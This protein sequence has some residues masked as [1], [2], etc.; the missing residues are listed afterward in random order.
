MAS[1]RVKR[2]GTIVHLMIS[3]DVCCNRHLFFSAPLIV[4]NIKE[5]SL[6]QVIVAVK[7]FCEV[8][9]IADA[10]RDREQ[11]EG[12]LGVRFVFTWLRR[13]SVCVLDGEVLTLVFI[14]LIDDLPSWRE[15]YFSSIV[16]TFR[17]L[18]KCCRI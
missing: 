7:N 2:H 4:I 15:K 6:Q 16:M 13:V 9:H 8:Y 3:F 5:V 11:T 1:G 17:L 14:S 10:V 12:D 18:L